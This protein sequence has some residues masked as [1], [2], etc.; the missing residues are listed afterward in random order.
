MALVEVILFPHI[1]IHTINQNNTWAANTKC[2]LYITNIHSIFLIQGGKRYILRTSHHNVTTVG[3]RHIMRAWRFDVHWIRC[4]CFGQTSFYRHDIT[5]T[6]QWAR[7]RLKS[8]APRLFTQPF[9]QA[10]IKKS[11]L[12]AT[13]LCEGNTPV[14]GEFPAQKASK[15]ENVSIWWRHHDILLYFTTHIF[16]SFER[17]CPACKKFAKLSKQTV[18]KNNHKRTLYYWSRTKPDLIVAI[19]EVV[20]YPEA[21]L[22]AGWGS[23]DGGDIFSDCQ[24]TFADDISEWFLLTGNC[25]ISFKLHW[26]ADGPI[27]DKTTLIPIMAWHRTCEKPLSC[28]IAPNVWIP[29]HMSS[30]KRHGNSTVCFTTF[31]D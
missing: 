22:P 6:S 8:P 14:T 20:N 29:R 19:P 21:V 5:L 15:A 27:D 1:S 30:H 13:G 18:D 23:Q 3:L 24:Q 16:D 12:R 26:G 17:R 31:P 9:I 10:Q 4:V 11:K 7:W 28:D 25:Y 2:V